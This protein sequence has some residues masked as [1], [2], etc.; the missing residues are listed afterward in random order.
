MSRK[1]LV[2][3]LALVAFCLI[4]IAPA[5]ADDTKAAPAKVEHKE[6]AAKTAATG[7]HH[8]NMASNEVA[9]CACGKVFQPNAS[10]KYIEANG[11]TYACCSDKCH[12]MGS[13]D[14]AAA[15]KMAEENTAKFLAGA[16]AGK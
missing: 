15:A 9:V 3:M 5:M 14:P 7:M 12:E 6:S 16:A 4:Q 10:T 13:K 2:V 11:K 1:L 8:H